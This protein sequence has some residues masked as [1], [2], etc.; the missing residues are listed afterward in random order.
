M[1]HS[2]FDW[3]QARL[4]NGLRLI[5]IS[6]PGT[7]TVAVRAYLRAGSRYDL[8]HKPPDPLHPPLGL[9]HLAEH[10]L[11]K[12]THHRSPR[13]IF[14]AVERLGGVIDAGT[15]KE[16]LT[17]SAV[18]P[19]QGLATALD[20]L[21]EVLVE[22]ALREEDF[23]QEK[24]VALDEIRHAQDS[25]GIIFDLFAETLWQKHPLRHPIL[26]TLDG[27][28]SLDYEGLLAFCQQ[29]YVIGNTLLAL[30]GDIEHEQ[31][32]RFVTDRFTALRPGPARLPSVV[33]ESRMQ[34]PRQAHL[35]KSLHQI[36]LLIGVPTVSMKHEDRSA[37]KALERILGMGA[38]ARLY[39]RLREQTLSVYNVSTVTAHYEDV[40][41]FAVHTACAPEKTLTVRAAI[42]EEWDKLR[43]EWVSA[44]ELSAAKSNY[45]GTL[46]RRFE[47]NLALAGIFGVEGLLHQ[48][49]PFDAAVQRMDAVQQE[50]IQRVAQ[51]YL[52]AD[53]CVTVTVGRKPE[54]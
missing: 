53:Q 49:E 44:D 19:R 31:A 42:L 11:F 10:L 25:E 47:T 32:E 54:T 38:S 15:T 17:L 41:Y 2:P 40:G 12:G 22:P 33:R 4:P 9:A 30:C 7:A 6:R 20:V 51:K 16:Y 27:L 29:R 48:V 45:A 5:T 14:A 26:G 46:T 39:Q 52:R 3:R 35:E 36:H 34:E 28:R 8:E 43:Q 18:V 37:L 50:D 23:W 21:A 1:T 13:E 24:L